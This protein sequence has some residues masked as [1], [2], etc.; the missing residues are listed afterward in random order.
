[1]SPYRF[2]MW[3]LLG[4]GGSIIVIDEP[5]EFEKY[6]IEVQDFN[7]ITHHLK[8]IYRMYLKSMKKN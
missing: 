3:G 2:P 1:M 7:K 8:G 6:S 4:R 5:V